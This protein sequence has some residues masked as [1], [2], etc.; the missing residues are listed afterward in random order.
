MRMHFT[1]FTALAVLSAS[2]LGTAVRIPGLNGKFI[3]H[4]VSD[5]DGYNLNVYIRDSYRDGVDAHEKRFYETFHND[6]SKF[7]ICAETTFVDDY[8]TDGAL[9]DD[10]STIQAELSANPGYF[11]TGDYTG[12]E[13]NYLAV[14]GTCA[15]GVY[16]LDGSSSAVNIGSK[17]IVDNI[18]SALIRFQRTG[19]VGVKGNFTCSDSVPI[20]WAIMKAT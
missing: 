5:T 12:S 13:Y 10:C 7:E 8:T 2:S 1:K 3:A 17:D 4:P 18:N 6:S 19:H 20:S 16:R 9:G 15:F 14:C 11:E